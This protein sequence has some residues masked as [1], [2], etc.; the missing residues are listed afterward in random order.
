M[1][2]YNSYPVTLVGGGSLDK[3]DL[4][5][6]LSMGSYIVAA[7]G[8]AEAAINHNVLPNAIIGDFDSISDKSLSKIPSDAQ[9]RIEEQ[10]STDFDKC[11]RNID[12]PLILAVGFTGARIDHQL[13]AFNTLVRHPDKR[14]I[15]LGPCDTVFLAPPSI[16]LDLPAGTTVSLFPMGAVEG[17]SEGLKWPI[18]GICFTPDGQIG[19]SNE[20]TGPVSLALTAPKM[21]VTVPSEHFELVANALQNTASH[22]PS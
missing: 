12:S 14:C 18:S 17:H 21:L 4:S 7:D 10:D 13:A 16:N 5:R 20:A 3:S 22:W 6:A 19:T 1:I 9:H 2:V 8:G 11:L 15:L